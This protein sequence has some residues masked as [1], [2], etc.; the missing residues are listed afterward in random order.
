M[1]WLNKPWGVRLPKGRGT[2]HGDTAP[3][4]VLFDTNCAPQDIFLRGKRKYL[5]AQFVEVSSLKR[6][7]CLA[8]P[9]S[10]ILFNPDAAAL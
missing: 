5:G 10:T 1:K 3:E 4:N 7:F 9:T 2:L 6:A 8:N